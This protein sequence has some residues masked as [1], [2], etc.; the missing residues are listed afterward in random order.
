MLNLFICFSILLL[1]YHFDLINNYSTNLIKIKKRWYYIPKLTHLIIF[2]DFINFLKFFFI[3][4]LLLTSFLPNK[5]LNHNLLSYNNHLPSY[6]SYLFLPLCL[7]TKKF[8]LLIFYFF[9]IFNFNSK[10]LNFYKSYY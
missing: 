7:L 2:Q 6:L 9:F 1:W 4:F 10:F 8:S 3:I 5:S